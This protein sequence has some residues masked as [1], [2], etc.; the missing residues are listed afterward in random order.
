MGKEGERE[1]CEWGEIE[2]EGGVWVGRKERKRGRNV[3]G[4][5]WRERERREREDC[6]W[7]VGRRE[8]EECEWGKREGK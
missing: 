7:G 8:R 2:R 1:E 5:K 4:K 6:E 3:S